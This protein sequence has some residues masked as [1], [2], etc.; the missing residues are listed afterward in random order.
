LPV[1]GR[2]PLRLNAVGTLLQDVNAGPP[3]R[4]KT[5]VLKRTTGHGRSITP[6]HTHTRGET[7]REQI[8]RA[9]RRWPEALRYAVERIGEGRPA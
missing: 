6:D 4:Q 8:E 2:E 5:Q 1:V 9:L 7:Q 3:I